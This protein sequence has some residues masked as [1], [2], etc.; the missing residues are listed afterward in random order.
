M[1]KR[2]VALIAI[3]GL[4]AAYG[5]GFHHGR[6]YRPV[7]FIQPPREALSFS[8]ENLS[9]GFLSLREPIF[10]SWDTDSGCVVAYSE[11]PHFLDQVRQRFYLRYS[12]LNGEPIIRKRN[13]K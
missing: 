8:D 1:K 3:A 6:A 12:P 11:T 10:L 5:A 7:P 9:S 2:T 4:G 13:E